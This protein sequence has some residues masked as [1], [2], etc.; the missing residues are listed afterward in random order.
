MKSDCHHYFTTNDVNINE[1]EAREILD[2]MEVDI[3]E[4]SS[5]KE[6]SMAQAM[7]AFASFVLYDEMETC[8]EIIDNHMGTGTTVGALQGGNDLDEIYR[9]LIN[10]NEHGACGELISRFRTTSKGRKYSHLLTSH[11]FEEYM[12]GMCDRRSTWRSS[13]RCTKINNLMFILTFS[14]QKGQVRHID[15]INPNLQICLFMSNNCPSTVIY[16]LEEPDIINGEQLVAYWEETRP[17]P[18]LVK[19]MLLRVNTSK[20]LSDQRHTKYFSFWGTVDDNLETFGKLYRPVSSSVAFNADPGVTLIAGGNEVHA[21]P[22]NTGARMFAF[23]VGIPEDDDDNSTSN[24]SDDNERNSGGDEDANGEIQYC[25]AL[26]HVDLTCILFI[27]MEIDF[28]NRTEEHEGAKRFLLELLMSLI[29]DQPQETY[30]RL[31][32]DDRSD[33]RDWLGCVARATGRGDTHEI[34]AFLKAAIQSDTIF[35]SPDMRGRSS[36]HNKI[37]KRRARRK[38]KKRSTKGPT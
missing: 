29:E 10:D 34:D 1:R 21:G 25:P 30:E 38:D 15:K 17:V 13:R 7:D 24:R 31:L 5:R 19:C 4:P 11:K 14:D 16:H 12:V 36:N 2:M 26:L 22:K 35:Y 9:V 3:M 32:S 28:A 27:T 8:R 6:E 18:Y 37:N 33:L 23:A 20:R